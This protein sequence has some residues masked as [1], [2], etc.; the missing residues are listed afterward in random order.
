M[1]AKILFIAPT[2]T[3]LRPDDNA[4]KRLQRTAGNSFLK[5]HECTN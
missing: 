4:I 2:I 1:E 3:R 5:D